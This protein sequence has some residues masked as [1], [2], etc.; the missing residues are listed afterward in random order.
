MISQMRSAGAELK[1]K[2]CFRVFLCQLKTKNS[3]L[4]SS[5]YGWFK[6]LS[7]FGGLEEINGLG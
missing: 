2:N 3:K 4:L 6:K 5:N 7:G 1:T